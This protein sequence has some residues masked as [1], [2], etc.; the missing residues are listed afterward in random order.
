MEKLR[1]GVVGVGH[2]GSIHA[3]VYSGLE[4]VKL[5]GV[6]DFNLE[7]SIEIGKR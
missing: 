2:L 1:I 6:C 3:K 7:R 5:V 4:N